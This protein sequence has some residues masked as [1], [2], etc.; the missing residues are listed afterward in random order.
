MCHLAQPQ[1]PFHHR[2]PKDYAFRIHAVEVWSCQEGGDVQL[3]VTFH[4]DIIPPT[5][6]DHYFW[7]VRWM[8]KT[9]QMA[10]MLIHHTHNAS[11]LQ[12]PSMDWIDSYQLDIQ[13]VNYIH[14]PSPMDHD[15]FRDT[16]PIVWDQLTAKDRTQLPLCLDRTDVDWSR[17]GTWVGDVFQPMTCRIDPIRPGTP[18]WTLAFE[19]KPWIV[20]L[21]SSIE[22]GLLL[23]LLDPFLTPDE[24]RRL[25]HSRPWKCWGWFDIHRPELRLTYIDDRATHYHYHEPSVVCHNNTI[26]ESPTMSNDTG[27]VWDRLLRDPNPPDIIW[28]LLAI[29]NDFV[30]DVLH[31]IFQRNSFQGLFA[32]AHSTAMPIYSNT[33]KEEYL[34]H[35]KWV[36]RVQSHV[37]TIRQGHANSLYLDL[38]GPVHGKLHTLEGGDRCYRCFNHMHRL[39]PADEVSTHAICGSVMW[40]VID[41]LLGRLQREPRREPRT[42]TESKVCSDCPEGLLPFHV[43]TEPHFICQDSIQSWGGA[44]GKPYPVPACPAWCMQRPPRRSFITHGG[45]YLEERACVLSTEFNAEVQMPQ[46]RSPTERAHAP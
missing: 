12:F 14:D 23:T 2:P 41:M 16:T 29:N 30:R 40:F 8:G 43:I 24:R 46:V 21:G 31:P 33:W 3:Q 13:L 42:L 25:P 27:T 18:A 11:T 15:V 35:A 4:H 7:Y 17:M 5:W 22:R 34:E 10:G 39:C 38:S 6:Y 1:H 20:I 28:M 36:E 19:R 9:T 37:D 44:A 26:P 32:S 45:A